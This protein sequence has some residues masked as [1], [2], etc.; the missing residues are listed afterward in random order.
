MRLSLFSTPSV[1]PSATLR[2]EAP[3]NTNLQ[4]EGRKKTNYDKQ[5]T[6]AEEAYRKGLPKSQSNAPSVESD[7]ISPSLRLYNEAFDHLLFLLSPL[8]RNDYTNSAWD[9]LFPDARRALS[10]AIK[11]L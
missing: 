9:A 3:S 7:K 6:A 2:T 5:V 11:N 10:E 8:D 4:R 1:L